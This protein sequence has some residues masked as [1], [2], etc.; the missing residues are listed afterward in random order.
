MHAYNILC[1]RTTQ[2][3]DFDKAIGSRV[4]KILHKLVTRKYLHIRVLYVGV[5]FLCIHVF[6]RVL[7]A[8]DTNF[9]GC[10]TTDTLS[11]GNVVITVH[12]HFGLTV[13]LSF[14]YVTHTRLI[15][16]IY[17]IYAFYKIFMFFEKLLT[18]Q[19]SVMTF[20]SKELML[21]NR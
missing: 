9:K 19:V 4:G 8:V 18:H 7:Y 21:L 11:Y 17:A 14:T 12:C 5:S 10:F 15:Q 16:M 1:L 3:R 13:C 6:R 2:S 20:K